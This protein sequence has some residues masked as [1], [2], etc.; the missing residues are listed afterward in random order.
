MAFLSWIIGSS[1]AF[2][3]HFLFRFVQRKKQKSTAPFFSQGDWIRYGIPFG[4]GFLL[5]LVFFFCFPR[6]PFP[7]G[8]LPF[9]FLCLLLCFVHPYRFFSLRGKDLPKRK[10]I[11]SSL[12]MLGILLESFACNAKAYPMQGDSFPY[13]PLSSS[14]S[15]N[16]EAMEDGS[17]R[18]HEGSY[19]VLSWGREDKPQNIGLFFLEQNGSTISA[20]VSYSVDGSTFVS[21]GSYVLDTSN[22]N[23]NIL[24]LPRQKEEPIQA[25]R[26]D[27][28][29]QK[30]YY[31]S[32][33][34]ATLSSFSLNVPFSFHY[35]PLRFG[36]YSCLVLFFCYLP[37]FASKK[38]KDLSGKTPYLILGGIA[39]VLLIG[40][41]SYAMM[42]LGDFATPYPISVQDL[43]AHITSSTG[44]T[45]IFVSLFDAFKKGRVDLD[46]EVDPKLLALENPWSPSQ[47]SQAGVSY[48][49]DHAFYG[50]KYYSYYGPMPVIL[51]SF[52]FYFLTGGKYALNAFGLEAFGM[53]FLIPAF[54]LLLLEIFRLVQKK[55]NWIEY[56]FFS[57]M[58]LSTSMMILA[59]TWKDGSCHEAIYHVP[60]IYGLAFFDLFFAFVLQA[61]RSKRL[62]IL[63]LGFAGLFFVFLVFTRPNLFLGLLITLPFLLAIL[64]EKGVPAK[65][66]LID[67]APMFGVLVLGAALACLYN[68]ARFDSILEFGQ[69][70]QLNVADQRNLTYSAQKLLPTFFHFFC[71]GGVF[72]DEFPYLSCSVQRYSFETTSLAPYVTGYYGLLGIPLFWASLLNPFFFWKG[73]GKAEKAMGILFPAFLFLFAFTTY[74][75]AGVCPRYLIEFFHL[76]TLGSAFALL[77]IKKRTQDTPAANWVA[78]GSF[79]VLGV[80]AFLCLSLSFDSFD[81]MKAG[82][83]FGLLLRL[84]EAFF[85]YNF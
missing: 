50:G 70:Y 76:A 52:P 40:V 84:K 47:R 5:A 19:F 35:S 48:Y 78:G 56:A 51:V 2:L 64:L 20:K 38:G 72:Y 29:F 15:G 66:K 28:S 46:L 4:F 81:G 67:F 8:S 7:N 45:D 53:A 23:S 18:L 12:L 17:L 14:L 49:W 71:Q 41:F 36:A 59:F 10:I 57:A 42:N 33:L 13:S 73:S 24:P 22:G 82:N 25:Y 3:L 43:H 79:L 62:R 39:S 65:R 30:G 68:Y 83:C 80:S 75:K 34:S 55:V 61:Y 6:Y 69:S 60:D 74:S 11:C 77:Q 9:F 31:A 27:F 63:P 37:Y 26:V 85:A 54:L 16:Y 44:K 21:S 58:G 1:A 32:P